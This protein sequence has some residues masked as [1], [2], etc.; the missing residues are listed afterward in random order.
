[1]KYSL[2]RKS[3]VQVISENFSDT[4]KSFGAFVGCSSLTGITYGIVRN[5]ELASQRTGVI[6]DKGGIIPI[7]FFFLSANYAKQ[8]Y[9][10]FK[11]ER[12]RVHQLA[13]E[14]DKER[15]KRKEEQK[16]SM[17]GFITPDQAFNLEMQ[18]MLDKGEPIVELQRYRDI[19]TSGSSEQRE[20]TT[21]GKRKSLNNGIFKSTD[22]Y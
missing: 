9:N 5:F 11:K 17:E 1:M 10:N 2:Q 22:T 19:L 6:E 20:G 16:K 3:Y 7:M 12:T 14:I 18:K 21:A 8:V 15:A 13:L 4:I